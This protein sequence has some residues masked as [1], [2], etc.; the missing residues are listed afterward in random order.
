[1]FDPIKL[2]EIKCDNVEVAQSAQIVR[3]RR[4]PDSNNDIEAAKPAKTLE[5]GTENRKAKDAGTNFGK[6][7]ANDKGWRMESS[8]RRRES[9]RPGQVK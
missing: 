1:M 7:L 9:A 4:R 2:H 6:I 5:A 3:L 8:I